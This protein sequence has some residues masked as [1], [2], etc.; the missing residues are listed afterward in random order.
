MSA[1]VL[2]FTTRVTKLCECIT[3]RV[4]VFVTETTESEL[5]NNGRSFYC[6]NGHSMSYTETE[7]MRLQKQIENLKQRE[8]WALEGKA[9]ALES[10][11]HQE[12]RARTYKG[13]VTQLKRRV[14]NGV[15]PCCK[16]TFSQLARH[17][18]CKHPEYAGET[19]TE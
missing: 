15:C 10:A 17:M 18:A 2:T 3:C 13:K 14:G 5:R 1:V 7:T 16:R 11:R 12:A 9:R 19:E 4:P 6:H 8:Q